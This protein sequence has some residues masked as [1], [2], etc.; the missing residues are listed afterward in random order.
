MKQ[1]IVAI[2][3]KHRYDEQAWGSKEYHYKTFVKDLNENDLV[4]VETQHGYSV[5]NVV[6]YLTGSNHAHRH[7]IQK[8][9][10]TEHENYLEKEM[11]LSFLQAEIKERAEELRERKELE[12]LAKEDKELKELLGL[13]DEL[14]N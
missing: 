14:S 10:V 5:A 4:V 2:Q 3:F 7:V 8:V 9:D 13:V 1:Y 12:A 6:R 11:K